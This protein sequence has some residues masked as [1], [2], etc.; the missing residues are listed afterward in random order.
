MSAV[1]K[2]TAQACTMASTLGEALIGA[3]CRLSSFFLAVRH[4]IAVRCSC[5]RKVAAA[6]SET[7]GGIYGASCPAVPAHHTFLGRG[8][9]R[10]AERGGLWCSHKHNCTASLSLA[11]WAQLNLLRPETAFIG[12][13]LLWGSACLALAAQ[14]LLLRSC[15]L[16]PGCT[17]PLHPWGQLPQWLV[18]ACRHYLPVNTVCR[19][20][21]CSLFLIQPGTRVVKA[22]C[23]LT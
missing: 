22:G 21:M 20:V 2:N 23:G 1:L 14:G 12:F 9:D 16:W 10:C 4:S 3:C 19:V 13:R 8:H 6:S 17:R 5:T 11:E 18:Y 7:S 15:S